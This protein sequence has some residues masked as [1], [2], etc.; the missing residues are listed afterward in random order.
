MRRFNLLTLAIVALAAAVIVSA[1]AAARSSGESA[2]AV[3]ATVGVIA[4]LVVSVVGMWQA[5]ESQQRALEHERHRL[6]EQHRHERQLGLE[7]RIVSQRV[8]Q[9]RDLRAAVRHNVLLMEQLQLRVAMTQEEATTDQREELARTV[10]R[11]RAE[12]GEHSPSATSTRVVVASIASDELKRRTMDW[13]R[14]AL[15]LIGIA[16][17]YAAAPTIDAS[18]PEFHAGYIREFHEA[19][20]AF[21]RASVA[22]AQEIER[23]A[24]GADVAAH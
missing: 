9:V 20:P 14:E 19:H 13:Y 4:T 6:D 17:K 3:T 1:I 22:L 16:G 5:R 11:A 24:T 8:E 18:H 15:K 7:E 2:T 23:Y 21:D 10:D 12:L